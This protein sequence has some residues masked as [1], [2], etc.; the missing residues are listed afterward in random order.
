MGLF[1]K[2]RKAKREDDKVWL[3]SQARW[4]GIC[5]AVRESG[6]GALIVAHFE[7]SLNYIASALDAHR[8]PFE[9]A[10]ETMDR[11][12]ITDWITGAGAGLRPAP[13]GGMVLLTLSELLPDPAYLPTDSGSKA[14]ARL[15]V[16]ERH[17]L[18][19]RDAQIDAFADALP[20]STT[21]EYHIALDDPLMRLFGSDQV[22]GMFRMMNVGDEMPIGSS[23]L[24]KSIEAAQQK[25]EKR[26]SG[27]V[28]TASA[29]DWF[30]LNGLTP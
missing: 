7:E 27:D 1:G 26:V 18:R 22:A 4:N 3:T 11:S 17:P 2:R 8:I 9:K 6:Q 13:A 14:S 12:L 10:I 5:A 24:N 21:L 25:I 28:R 20:R 29:E 15:L 30:R 23:M 16:I 19:V